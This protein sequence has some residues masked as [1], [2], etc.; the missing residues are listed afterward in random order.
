M[1]AA[2]PANCDVFA[3]ELPGFSPRS[4]LSAEIVGPWYAVLNYP[5]V[6]MEFALNRRTW[7]AEFC[8]RRKLRSR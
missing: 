7:L 1:V 3:E 2:G 8:R 6:A 5:P 4:S